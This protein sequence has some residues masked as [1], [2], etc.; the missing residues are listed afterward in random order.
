MLLLLQYIA[1]ISLIEGVIPQQP[2]FVS[3]NY[4]HQSIIQTDGRTDGRIYDRQYRVAHNS[5]R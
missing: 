3:E 4:V 1:K 5:A 2:F